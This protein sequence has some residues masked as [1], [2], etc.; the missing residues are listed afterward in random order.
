M[1]DSGWWE[2]GAQA[3]PLVLQLTVPGHNLD[4]GSQGLAACRPRNLQ[5]PSL[6][7]ELVLEDTVPTL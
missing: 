1:L 4:R 2:G 5:P 3:V 6:E 7:Y